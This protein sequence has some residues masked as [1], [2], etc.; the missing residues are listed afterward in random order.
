MS[1]KFWKQGIRFE[2]QGTGRCCAS[3]GSYGYVYLTLEDRRRFAKYFKISTLAFTRRH[4][5]KTNGYFH[6]K[7]IKGDCQFLEGKGCS[8]YDARPAQCRTWPFWPENMNARTWSR[9]VKAFCPGVG[10]GKLYSEAEIKALLAQDPI[11]P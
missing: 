4:C 7:E 6:L 8:A 3:R 10:K 2:C 5:A 9:E 1:E 11:D